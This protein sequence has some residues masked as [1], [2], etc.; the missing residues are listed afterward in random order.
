MFSL[1]IYGALT[2]FLYPADIGADRVRAS[3][4]WAAAIGIAWIGVRRWILVSEIQFSELSKVA[5]YSAITLSIFVI[6][7]FFLSNIFGLYLSDVF[8]FSVDKF[9]QATVFTDSIQRPR[10]FSAEAGFTSMVFELLLPLSSFHWK[11]VNVIQKTFYIAISGI[12]VLLLLSS[13]AIISFTFSLLILNAVRK[14]GKIYLVLISVVVFW[15][16][17]TIFR[18]QELTAIFGYKFLEFFDP[19][20]YASAEGSRQEALAAGQ[21]LLSQNWLGIGWGTVLQDGKIPGSLIDQLIYGNGLISLWLEFAVATGVIG[22]TLFLGVV[23]NLLYQLSKIPTIEAT[24]CFLALCMLVLHHVAV[25]EQ[26]FPMLWFALALSQIVVANPMYFKSI[27]RQNSRR[28]I[29]PRMLP[30][31]DR[32]PV[33]I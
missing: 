8:Y 13:A 10:G 20:K 2:W 22:I 17:L 4:Q 6:F 31:K 19:L 5:F 21:Y 30:F 26:W 25:F 29:P 11:R 24:S 15:I 3:S 12:A 16:V 27:A 1:L 28:V 32:A 23:V 33:S 9:P 18:S 14:G 7:E